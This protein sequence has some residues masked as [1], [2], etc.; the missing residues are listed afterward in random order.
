MKTTYR[1][2]SQAAVRSAFWE[3]MPPHIRPRYIACGRSEKTGRMKYRP[4]TQNEYPADTRMAFVDFVDSL[5]RDG[6]IS[7]SLAHNVTL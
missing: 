2:T 5:S 6:M 1:L 3:S 7:A 4:R